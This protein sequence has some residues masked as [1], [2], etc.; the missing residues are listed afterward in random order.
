MVALY[1]DFREAHQKRW[2][3]SVVEVDPRKYLEG[4]GSRCWEVSDGFTAVRLMSVAG[5]SKEEE[6]RRKKVVH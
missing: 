5:R 1:F 4:C 6:T 2:L 3:F